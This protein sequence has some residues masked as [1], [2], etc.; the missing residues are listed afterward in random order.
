MKDMHKRSIGDIFCT[1]D[2]DERFIHL[3][4]L[5]NRYY[6]ITG[7]PVL[8]TLG[9]SQGGTRPA[10]VYPTVECSVDGYEYEFTNQWSVGFVDSIPDDKI[11]KR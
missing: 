3:S 2:R 1:A 5:P 8:S 7:D 10:L 9:D 11:I 6:K 4:G